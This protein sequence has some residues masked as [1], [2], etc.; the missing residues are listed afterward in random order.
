M[1][2]PDKLSLSG[3]EG[4]CVGVGF[5]QSRTAWSVDAQRIAILGPMTMPTSSPLIIVCPVVVC[6]LV[7]EVVSN[8]VTMAPETAGA[9]YIEVDVD[10]VVYSATTVQAETPAVAVA[11][12]GV[13]LSI[14]IR[15][16]LKY[17][18]QP[19]VVSQVYE[20]FCISIDV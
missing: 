4:G 1:A 20:L 3:G 5:S 7:F 11:G 8:D 15:V 6:A 12:P 10:I 17:E 9:V 2:P 18:T 13:L 16:G 19:K 14:A